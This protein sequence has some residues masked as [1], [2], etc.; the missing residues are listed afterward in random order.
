MALEFTKHT[1][2]SVPGPPSVTSFSALQPS[3]QRAILD[4]PIPTQNYS[5]SDRSPRHLTPLSFHPLSF[6]SPSVLSHSFSPYTHSPSSLGS[7]LAILLLSTS[8]T[9]LCLHLLS[10][11]TH[12]LLFLS[13]GHSAPRGNHTSTKADVLTDPWSPFS[14]GP[15]SRPAVQLS[16]SPSLLKGYFKLPPPFYLSFRDPPLQLS[17]LHPQKMAS[18]PTSPRSKQ[19]YF[20]L[21]PTPKLTCICILLPSSYLTPTCT[22][23]CSGLS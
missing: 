6:P 2:R 17:P 23:P 18:A 13:S 1:A 3:S 9:S 16:P 8:L 4:F 15:Q 22:P 11:S 20:Q 7:I 21:L 5:T 14:R 19:E 12:L 10:P